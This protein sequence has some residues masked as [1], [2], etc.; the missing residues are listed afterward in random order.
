MQAHSV[1]SNDY[2]SWFKELRAHQ[3][4]G[5]P[6][7]NS[8]KLLER[9]EGL[10][11]EEARA[12]LRQKSLEM[13]TEYHRRKKEY[14]E[15][16]AAKGISP[17]LV[18]FLDYHGQYATGHVVWCMKSYRHN[19]PGGHEHRAYYAKRV[20]EG[21]IFWDTPWQSENLLTGG[22]QV[23]YVKKNLFGGGV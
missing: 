11:V 18:R 10:S 21:A 12:Q 23:Q 15:T 13:D 1:Y 19:S 6:I 14:F 20:A 22:Y 5:V 3:E 4:S 2:Y 17:T 7:I 16:N 8:V 9:L